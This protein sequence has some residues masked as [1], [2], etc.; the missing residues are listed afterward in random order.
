MD[1]LQSKGIW[2]AYVEDV[3]VCDGSGTTGGDRVDCN[4]RDESSDS[5]LHCWLGEVGEGSGRRRSW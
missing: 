3:S 1:V 5:K 4:G 2:R